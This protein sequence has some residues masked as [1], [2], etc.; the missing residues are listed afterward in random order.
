MK[1]FITTIITIVITL[2]TMGQKEDHMIGSVSMLQPSCHGYSNGELTITP[3]GGH[4]PFTYI[5][6]NGET[7]QKISDLSA[8]N[9]SV[10]VTDAMG[11]QLEGVFILS[12]PE[13]I[14]IQG[15]TSNTQ[16]GQSNGSIDITNV[17]N[18]N[19]DY[20]WN[21]STNNGM[22]LDQTTLDQTNLKSGEYKITVTDVNG[23]QGNRIFNINGVILPFTNPNIFLNGSS[24]NWT[25]ISTNNNQTIISESK[26]ILDTMGKE[27]DFEYAPTGYYFIVKNGVITQKIYKN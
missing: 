13:M 17:N 5:W 1:T 27:I 9:Y 4:S 8:G 19:N 11:Q 3:S 18:I 6:S 2:T 24:V 10:L 20:T 26:I 22:N 7:T 21:W 15:I 16:L 14:T 25:S 23:C 12:E